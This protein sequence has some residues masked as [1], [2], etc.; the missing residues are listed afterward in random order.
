[1]AGTYP[2]CLDLSDRDVRDV[3][4]QLVQRWDDDRPNDARTLR[5]LIGEHS[6]VDELKERLAPGPML[7]DPLPDEIAARAAEIR[8]NWQDGRQT[9]PEG[10]SPAPDV[11]VYCETALKAMG[12]SPMV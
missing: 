5:C 11:R 8:E 1:M 6:G 12:E 3:L 4:W 10:R 7:D 2:F 9:V